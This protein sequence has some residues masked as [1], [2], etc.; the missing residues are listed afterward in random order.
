MFAW[1]CSYLSGRTIFMST[2]DD[3]S[4]R[5]DVWRS[6]PQGGVLSPILFNVI[7]AGLADELW[8]IQ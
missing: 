7:L 6:V 8:G 1:L 2:M 5:H 4:E 3:E